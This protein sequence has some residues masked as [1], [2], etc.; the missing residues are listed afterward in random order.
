MN[1]K[2]LAVFVTGGT[3]Y[4]GSR[5]IAELLARGHRV[6]ALVRAGSE[7]RL[8]AGCKPVP[9]DALDARTYQ[10]AVAGS[11]A[12]VHLVGVAHP[13]PHKARLFQAIDGVSGQ[14]A[15]KAA[16]AGRVGHFVYLS[17]AQPAPIMKAY[18]AVRAGCEAAIRASGLNA[19]FLRPWYVLG[20]G[21]SWPKIVLPIYKILE[22]FP[23]AR[24]G[25]RRLGFV[26]I[27]EMVRALVEALENP[28]VGVRVWEVPEIRDPEG[29]IRGRGEGS[30]RN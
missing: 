2:P 22:L 13:G 25:A 28:A 20:P 7:S 24:S 9:G 23:T 11:E 12:F 16:Q 1:P 26:T 8:P 3:G 18:V 6:S 15:L 21:R 17:V 29:A 5:L 14:E 19:T 10:A 4:I 27:D 30:G